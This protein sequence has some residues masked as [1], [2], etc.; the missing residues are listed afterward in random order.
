MKR[1][2]RRRLQH[3]EDRDASHSPGRHR[4]RACRARRRGRPTATTPR[5][6]GCSVETIGL[7]AA[8]VGDHLDE[9]DDR[10]REGR[11]GEAD[12]NPPG[13]LP[14][15]R[16]EDD[17]QRRQSSGRSLPGSCGL[18]LPGDAARGR[19]PRAPLPTSAAIRTSRSTSCRASRARG[20]ARATSQKSSTLRLAGSPSM[21]PGQRE[22]AEVV[23]AAASAPPPFSGSAPA[24]AVSL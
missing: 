20:R 7:A 17:R 16:E 12:R 21:L 23:L 10:L 5:T 15:R 14:D 3:D 6:S 9:G 24:S 13:D 19:G 2:H 1:G 11:E 8:A 4:P 18:R 22:E